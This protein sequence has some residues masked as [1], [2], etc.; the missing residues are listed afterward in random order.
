VT[1]VP[2]V[3]RGGGGG[4]RHRERWRGDR[5][6]GNFRVFLDESQTT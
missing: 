1:E 5:A 4:D 2:D 6:A 3:E